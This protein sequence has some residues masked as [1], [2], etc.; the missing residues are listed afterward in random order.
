MINGDIKYLFSDHPLMIL[1][2]DNNKLC[3]TQD[4]FTHDRTKDKIL[5][6]RLLGAVAI[7]IFNKFRIISD[8]RIFQFVTN[9]CE[10][11]K[12]KYRDKNGPF[13]FVSKCSNLVR[14]FN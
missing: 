5:E 14:R 10:K 2:Q 3:R 12:K 1:A 11:Q 7:N 8:V 9:I 13:F 4:S 6:D